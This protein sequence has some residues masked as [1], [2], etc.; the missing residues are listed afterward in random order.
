MAPT[1]V[2][3]AIGSTPLIELHHMSPRPGVRL[4]A[5]LEGCNPT[6]SVKDR[7][8][9]YLIEAAEKQEGLKRGI[10]LVEASTGNMALSLSLIAKQRGYGLKV[11]MPPKVTP[12]MRELLE[13]MG[14]EVVVHEFAAGMQGPIEQALSLGQEPGCYATR[15]FQAETNVR[16]HYETTGPEILAALPQVDMLIAGIGT[17][18]TITGVGRRLKEQNP[19]LQVI[20]VTPQPGDEI[21][22]IRSLEQ[23]Y[24]PPLL[25]MGLLDGRFL[26]DSV[27][28]FAA[29]RELLEKEGLFAGVSS[30]AVLH[31]VPQAAQRLNRG[32]IV[33]LLA[34]TGWR[35]LPALFGMEQLQALGG[36]P[37]NRAWW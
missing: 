25:D 27:S 30:G 1:D 37:D 17:G 22:G 16:A 4:F 32:N 28:S 29:M 15:Q 35:Y 13:L 23:G 11:V 8:A 5:K 33:V 14:A 36:H 21:Q 20:G 12:G 9:K 2:L 3:D 26:V 7:V 34:D 31:V 19:Q 6:G 18:G 10:T 24:V